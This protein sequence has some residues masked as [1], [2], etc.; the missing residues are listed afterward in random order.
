MA[1][2]T[3]QTLG[4]LYRECAPALLLYARQWCEG[5][6]DVVQDAF[7]KLAQQRN[8]PE[9][10]VAWLYTVV[11]NLVRM[12]SRSTGRRRQRETRA[13]SPEAWFS[14]VDDRLDA[15]R[16]AEV[17][18]ELPLDQREVIVAR[19]WGGLTFEE[20]ARLVGC[21]LPTAHRRYQAGLTELHER[22]EGRWIPTTT[23]PKT[24]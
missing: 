2:M 5:G 9:Q 6:E 21:S 17:L 3:P 7:V 12:A 20:I 13:S 18:G 8:A 4:R 22:L 24:I 1:P 15:R 11:R 23:L 10:P 19:L 16:A 14:T